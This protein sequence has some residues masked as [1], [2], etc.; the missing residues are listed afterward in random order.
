MSEERSVTTPLGE[1]TY[2]L[3]VKDVKNINLRIR[4]GKIQVSINRRTPKE[5]A[6]RFIIEKAQ[7]IMSTLSRQEQK[8]EELESRKTLDF[9]SGESVGIFGNTYTLDILKSDEESCVINGDRLVMRVCD[10]ESYGRK[11][12]LFQQFCAEQCRE[13]FTRYLSL[14]YPVLAP[15][16]ARKPTLAMK[17]LKSRWGSCKCVT[18]EICLNFAMIK[19]P[20]P[21]VEYVVLHEAVH[22]VVPNHSKSFYAL[23]AAIMPDFRKRDKLLN[24]YTTDFL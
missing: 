2:T 23:G 17:L 8:R 11:Y 16:G 9:V 20:M 24:A 13:V 14:F 6:D 18:G 21:L 12:I 15:L 1:I 19:L 10:T 3:S 22:L 7:W 5:R 4:N